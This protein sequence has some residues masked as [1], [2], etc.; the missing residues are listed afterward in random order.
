MRVFDCDECGETISAADDSELT[1]LV[2][3][4]Y[5]AEHTELDEEELEDKVSEGAYDATDS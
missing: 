2:A 3:K 5:A 1:R 4:H